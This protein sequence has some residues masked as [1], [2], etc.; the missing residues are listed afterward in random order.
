[1]VNWHSRLHNETT[2]NHIINTWFNLIDLM[3]AFK[4]ISACFNQTISFWI[5]IGRRRKM[6]FTWISVAFSSIRED[7]MLAWNLDAFRFFSVSITVL[8][9]RLKHWLNDK[10]SWYTPKYHSCGNYIVYEVYTVVIGIAKTKA[11]P[12]HLSWV[13]QVW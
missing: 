3:I 7:Y 8:L 10:W 9:P 4:N 13:G 5:Q 1:M 6:R 2:L 12:S 11:V